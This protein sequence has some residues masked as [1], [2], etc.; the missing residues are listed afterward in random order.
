MN[1]KHNDNDRKIYCDETFYYVKDEAQALPRQYNKKSEQ[2][3]EYGC[4]SFLFK[5]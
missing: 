4:D 5:M 1:G 2:D 3:H